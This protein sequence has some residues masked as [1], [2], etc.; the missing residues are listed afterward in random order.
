MKTNIF[1]FSGAP[2]VSN[3][4]QIVVKPAI[5]LL[6]LFYG[7]GVLLFMLAYYHDGFSNREA[8]NPVVWVQY[9]LI[10]R[11]RLVLFIALIFISTSIK[12]HLRKITGDL[13]TYLKYQNVWYQTAGGRSKKSGDF[14]D[15][16]DSLA[17][18]LINLFVAIA[19]SVLY[20]YLFMQNV[21]NFMAVDAIG[22]IVLSGIFINGEMPGKFGSKIKYHLQALRLIKVKP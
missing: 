8:L 1:S 7:L 20:Y 12:D 16:V 4:F 19:G 9:V 10:N 15:S 6:V 17:M 11:E 22:C 18:N 13:L 14:A 3:I 5:A 2:R 21:H